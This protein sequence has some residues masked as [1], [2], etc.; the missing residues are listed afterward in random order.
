[1][2]TSRR[3][4]SQAR[5]ILQRPSRDPYGD[6]SEESDTADSVFSF[7]QAASRYLLFLAHVGWES[8]KDSLKGFPVWLLPGTGLVS[9]GQG[10]SLRS[11][12][13]HCG[14]ENTTSEVKT[15]RSA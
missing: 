2:T 13:L 10:P 11:S 4:E 3:P 8:S 1:M 9:L 12:V 6:S 15:E 7:L 5:V 14:D